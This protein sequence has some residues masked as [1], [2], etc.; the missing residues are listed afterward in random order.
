LD[1]PT[2][3]ALK[4]ISDHYCTPKKTSA[5]AGPSKKHN[6]WLSENADLDDDSSSSSSSSFSDDDYD[7]PSKEKI[8]TRKFRRTLLR[9]ADP[10]AAIRARKN[11]KKDLEGELA[12]GSVRFLEAFGKVDQVSRVAACTRSGISTV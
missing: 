6:Y 2:Q 1:K 8:T 9:K 12:R 10:E 3:D 7:E 11:F 4:I 5:E